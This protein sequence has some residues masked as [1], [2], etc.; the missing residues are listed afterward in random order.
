MKKLM[1]LVLTGLFAVLFCAAAHA[2]QLMGPWMYELTS[3]GL[4]ITGYTGNEADVVIPDEIDGYGVTIIGSY[5]FRENHDLAS[6][7]IPEGITSIRNGA[8][9]AVPCRGSNSM[10]RTALCPRSGSIPMTR[11]AACSPAREA[12]HRRV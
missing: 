3:E 8:F 2:E 10:R 9:Y 5:A 6:V 7:V 12:L 11:A 4:V 1:T